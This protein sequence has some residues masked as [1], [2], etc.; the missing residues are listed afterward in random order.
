MSDRI[1]ADPE[2]RPAESEPEPEAPVGSTPEPQETPEAASA[3]AEAEAPAP[4][5]SAKKLREYQARIDALTRE[6]WEAR[7]DAEA[8]AQRLAELER[9]APQPGQEQDPVEVAKHQLRMEEGKRQFDAACNR[10]FAAGKTEFP[11]FEQAVTALAAVG[12]GQR[13][14]FLAAVTQLP[15]GHKVYR[16]L[17][18][19]LDEAA[20]VLA[21]P[22]MQMAVELAR[23]EA[24]LAANGSHEPAAPKSLAPPVSQAP[25]PIKPI[26][27]GSRAV[28][29]AADP[30]VSMAD[31][32]R[33]RDKEESER[34]RL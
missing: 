2:D 19:N 25:A 24:R 6:K 14:D 23:M 34:K 16:Q 33:I 22:P 1:L 15:E 11:D 8:R 10:V 21:L 29:S 27:G 13:F 32:I 9:P 30:K 20:R 28:L 17:A 18:S 12:A 3:E 31:F 4:E 5:D 26:G 7:R